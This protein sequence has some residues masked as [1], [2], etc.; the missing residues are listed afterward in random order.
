MQQYNSSP[1]DSVSHKIDMLCLGVIVILI[2]CSSCRYSVVL[3]DQ[4][5]ISLSCSLCTFYGNNPTVLSHLV[6]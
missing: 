1:R 6:L 5:I 4:I 3:L 2:L